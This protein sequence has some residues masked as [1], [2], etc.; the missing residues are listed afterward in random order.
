M[1]NSLL[2]SQKSW[3]LTYYILF[4]FSSSQDR[5]IKLLQRNTFKISSLSQKTG[6]QQFLLSA[7]KKIPFWGF[8]LTM[9]KLWQL[10]KIFPRTTAIAKTSS[11]LTPM[12][13][14]QCEE[15]KIKMWIC[16]S[17]QKKHSVTSFFL[18]GWS[19]RF[20]THIQ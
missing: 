14:L 4:F 7:D 20:T 8:I 10:L 19:S 2:G 12:E 6:E 17:S 15:R 16:N 3:L 11:L 13:K 18:P 9:F 5:Q 1:K